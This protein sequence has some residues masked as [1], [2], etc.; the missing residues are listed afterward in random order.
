MIC[1]TILLH[2]EPMKEGKEA[3][4]K[5]TLQAIEYVSNDD[6]GIV[7]SAPVDRTE[8]TRPPKL[9]P[10]KWVDKLLSYE[11]SPKSQ[12][13][14]FVLLLLTELALF[15]TDLESDPSIS[16]APFYSLTVLLAAWLLNIPLSLV[17]VVTSVMLRLYALRDNYPSTLPFHYAENLFITC[18]CYVLFTFLIIRKKTLLF[19]LRR[20]AKR[21][22]TA[23]RVLGKHQ[24][25]TS[26][27]RRAAA[28]QTR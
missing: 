10:T 2:F 21:V 5:M 16:F 9:K 25:L 26:K 23:R 11:P 28:R 18:L 4:S 12:A 19:R 3:A 22:S 14:I 27:I 6:A 17:I 24:R 8:P 15:G 20:H 1:A 13:L 7:K